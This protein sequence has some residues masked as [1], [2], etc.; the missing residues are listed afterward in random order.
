MG[1]IIAVC[2]WLVNRQSCFLLIAYC[3][4][5]GCWQPYQHRAAVILLPL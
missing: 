4:M 1:R 2:G 3:V 5:I